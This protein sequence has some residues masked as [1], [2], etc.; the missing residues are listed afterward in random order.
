MTHGSGFPAG[1]VKDIQSSFCDTIAIDGLGGAGDI[2]GLHIVHA[3]P[4]VAGAAPVG[5]AGIDLLQNQQPVTLIIGPGGNILDAGAGTNVQPAGSDVAHHGIGTHLTVHVHIAQ[6]NPALGSAAP[7]AVG[8]DD[9]HPFAASV[10]ANAV[11]IDTGGGADVELIGGDDAHSR[12]GGNVVSIGLTAVQVGIFHYV[13]HVQLGDQHPAGNIVA[14]CG[15]I[16]P[17]V[18]GE[19]RHALD[20]QLSSLFKLGKDPAALAVGA[21]EIRHF[22]G[23]GLVLG[24]DGGLGALQTLLLHPSLSA[25]GTHQEPHVIQ[26]SPA[27]HQL[28]LGSG[29]HRG[30]RLGQGAGR[31]VQNHRFRRKSGFGISAIAHGGLNHTDEVT[32]CP[33][34]QVRVNI[35]GCRTGQQQ[36][37]GQKNCR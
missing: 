27:S 15:G 23:C 22:L 8:F 9:A 31:G 34:C 37:R 29:G 20:A 32:A 14:A 7:V 10:A 1:G 5:A 3:D 18:G 36:H 28:H 17:L 6:V 11:K 25:A 24:Q 12:I 16:H 2:V 30:H 13:G 35:L 33:G 4:A 26:H 19:L 21:I